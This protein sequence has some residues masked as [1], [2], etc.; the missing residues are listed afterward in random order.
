MVNILHIQLHPGF[1][2][3]GIASALEYDDGVVAWALAQTPIK[4]AHV[5][6]QVIDEFS[7]MSIFLSAW[8]AG[9]VWKCASTGGWG[10]SLAG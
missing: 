6:G 1:E 2:I 5:F 7:L 3:D 8:R 4:K 9:W 10:Q